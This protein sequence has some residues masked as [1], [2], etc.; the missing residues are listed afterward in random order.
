MYIDDDPDFTS[1]G[2]FKPRE[3]GLPERLF[4][5]LSDPKIVKQ[6]DITSLVVPEQ[7]GVVSFASDFTGN[8]AAMVAMF[9]KGMTD[10]AQ[11][12]NYHA[13]IPLP[14][15]QRKPLVFISASTPPGM[16]NPNPKVMLNPVYTVTQTVSAPGGTGKDTSIEYPPVPN[17]PTFDITRPPNPDPDMPLRSTSTTDFAELFGNVVSH[18]GMNT[19]WGWDVP[20]FCGEEASPG[21]GGDP[22][23]TRTPLPTAN[24]CPPCPSAIPGQGQGDQSGGG[25]MSPWFYVFLVV[26]VL[27]IALVFFIVLVGVRRSK[28]HTKSPGTVHTHTHHDPPVQAPAQ[29]QPI[30]N[31][32]ASVYTYNRY[33]TP[34][35]APVPLSMPMSMSTSNY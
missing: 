34:T 26:Y 30:L 15:D 32:R 17:P 11:K 28:E 18:G 10:P 21:R 24:Q 6:G 12:R 5:M 3:G 13:Y 19:R 23:A 25:G 20:H 14:D 1:L 4:V 29:S 33:S 27:F 9:V 31:S 7:W 35:P 8:D 22:D 16:L 2:E